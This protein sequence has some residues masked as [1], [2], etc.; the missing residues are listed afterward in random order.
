MSIVLLSSGGLDSTLSAVLAAEQGIEIYPLFIDYGQIAKNRE[1]SAC[2]FAYKNFGLPEPKVVSVKGFGELFPSG[3]TNGD[4]DIF[5]DA[6]LPGRNLLF[7]LMGATYACNVGANSISISL[8]HEDLSL[9]PDQTKEFIT[10]AQNLISTMTGRELQILTPLMDFMKMDVVALAAKKGI[11]GTYSCHAGKK[12][13][14]GE[15][16]ACKEYNFN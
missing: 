6:F 12:K 1:L 16:I 4:L 9:F 13:P 8:L 10:K 14:C 5:E 11:T 3:L 2:Q 7:I 15:C